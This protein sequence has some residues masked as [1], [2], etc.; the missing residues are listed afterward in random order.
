[1]KTSLKKIVTLFSRVEDAKIKEISFDPTRVCFAFYCILLVIYQYD[2]T[3]KVGK[4]LHNQSW[5]GLLRI[6][7]FIP[8]QSFTLEIAGGWLFGS[9]M[10]AFMWPA[11]RLLRISICLGFTCYLGLFYSY[12]KIDDNLDIILVLA[13]AFIFFSTSERGN[14]KVLLAAQTLVLTHYFMAAV[15]KTL[16]TCRLI[17]SHPLSDVAKIMP[18]HIA[19]TLAE[20]RVLTS[21][22]RVVIDHPWLSA[23]LWI[24]VI[25]L[26]LGACLPLVSVWAWRHWWKFLV[27]FHWGTIWMLGVNFHPTS[28]FLIYIFAIAPWLGSRKQPVR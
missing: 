20:G 22:Q 4:G 17:A 23:A 8:P 9:L 25:L 26:Q 10:L 28:L 19:N 21:L 27:L 3:E 7:S 18:L 6:F 12:G 24:G 5:I 1:M 2:F 11:S 14:K 13:F 16:A 15:W